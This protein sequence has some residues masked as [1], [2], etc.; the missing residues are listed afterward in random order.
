MLTLEK[1]SALKVRYAIKFSKESEIKFISHLD[2]MRTIQRIIRRAKLPVE[3]SKGFNPHMSL[4]IAQPLSV[5]IY[6]T[7]EY[8]DIVLEK[9]LDEDEI[10][11]ALNENCPSGIKIIEVV[12]IP[13]QA[14]NEKKIPQSMALVEAAAYSIKINYKDVSKLNAE[15][16]ELLQKETWNTMKKSKSGEKEVNIKPM[17]KQI[18]HDISEDTLNIETII[19]CGSKENLSPE[20]LATFI[21]ENTEGANS[22]A[23]V[24]IKRKEIYTIDSKK[25]KPLVEFFRQS[26]KVN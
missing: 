1:G 11:K 22:E 2:L 5:G 6:S 15:L 7:G 16:K 23:F 3:Y 19:S 14:L 4:S 13:P 21:K 10:K 26:T 12:K 8:M 20:L 17:I 18:N 25:I 24:D 9:E